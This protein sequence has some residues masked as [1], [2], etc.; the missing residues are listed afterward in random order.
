MGHEI[1]FHR[2]VAV[3]HRRHRRLAVL[4]P[5]QGTDAVMRPDRIERLQLGEGA[6]ETF[7]RRQGGVDILWRHAIGQQRHFQIVLGRS[8]GEGPAAGKF[9]RVEKVGE[10]FRIA[11]QARRGDHHLGIDHASHPAGADGARHKVLRRRH[12]IGPVW[13]AGGIDFLDQAFL[14]GLGGLGQL[15]VDHVGLVL[16]AVHHGADIGEVTVPDSG[17]HIHIVAGGERMHLGIGL[18]PAVRPRPG[19]D[20]ENGWGTGEKEQGAHQQDQTQA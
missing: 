6:V 18:G 20:G 5:A 19:H 10:C 3:Q 4:H 15:E 1:L 8:T 16:P 9:P 14:A 11:A 13:E 2:K 12:A 7:R 17:A